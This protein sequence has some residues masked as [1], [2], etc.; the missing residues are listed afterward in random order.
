MAT[1]RC[2]KWLCLEAV[3]IQ[4]LCDPRVLELL[5]RGELQD[6]RHEQLLN[7]HCSRSTLVEHLLEQNPLVRDM[8]VDDPQAIPSCGDNEAVVQ[9]PERAEIGQRR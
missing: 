8:L 9:L 7:L 6:Q 3:R 1:V 4:F 5:S 2:P